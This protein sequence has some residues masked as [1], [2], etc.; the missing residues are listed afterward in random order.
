MELSAAPEA[1]GTYI[2][3]VQQ[4]LREDIVSGTL[5]PWEKLRVAEL[6]SRYTMGSSPLREALSRLVGEGLVTFE[7]NKGFRVRGL[8]RE[9]LADIAYMR[10]AVETFAIRTAIERGGVEWEGGI[11]SALHTLIALTRDT[12]TDRASLDAWNV[13]HDRFHEALLS[14][15][16]SPRV[17]ETQRRLAEHHNRYRRIFMGENLPRQLL[18]DEHTNIA[19]AA[20]A[21]NADRAAGLL[22]QHM[23]VT[24]EFYARVLAGSEDAIRAEISNSE[25]L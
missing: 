5:A 8:S 14:A 18:I 3:A 7:G 1:P 24:S 2:E 12:A 4:R 10:T 25:F 23:V 16:G 13:A 15:C 22:G 6:K 19:D 11:V 17:L 20:L 9:D 21:R